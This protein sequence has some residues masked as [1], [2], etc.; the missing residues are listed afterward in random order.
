VLT[1]Q[2]T[3]GA[4]AGRDQRSVYISSFLEAGRGREGVVGRVEGR[5]VGAKILGAGMRAPWARS[6]G[7]VWHVVIRK[8]ILIF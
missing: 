7:V 6:A 1:K 4:R 8:I 2:W 5:V 3:A